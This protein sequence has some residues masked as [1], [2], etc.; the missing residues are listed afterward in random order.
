MD[1]IFLNNSHRASS[2]QA[3][4]WACP[5]NM[6]TPH[7]HYCLVLDVVG[8]APDNQPG[9]WKFMSAYLVQNQHALHVV[10][11]DLESSLYIVLWAALKYSRTHM[12]NA[13]WT[14]LFKEIFETE[15]VEKTRSFMIIGRTDLACSPVFINCK[16]A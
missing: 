13:Q 6:L 2:F 7:S 8:E 11:D 14:L 1:P 9:T 5:H 12:T 4:N 15:E 10:E 16:P 3:A